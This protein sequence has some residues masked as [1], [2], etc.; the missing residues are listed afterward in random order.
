VGDCG[1]VVAA[2][3]VGA[4]A[5]AIWSALEDRVPMGACAR[6]RVED[7]FSVAALAENTRNVLLEGSAVDSTLSGS[8]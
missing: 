5:E 8:V 4:M 7:K 6:R 2:G 3:E 1:L